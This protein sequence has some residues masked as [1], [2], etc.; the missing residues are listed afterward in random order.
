MPACP[1][2]AAEAQVRAW[3]D[4]V[5]VGL[6]ICPFAK[7]EIEAGRVRVCEPPAE[8]L[9]QALEAFADEALELIKS[10]TPATTLLVFARGFEGFND[11][12]NLL[13]MSQALLEECAWD[14][15]L[16]LASF[17]PDYCFEG[18]APDDVTNYTN[19][20]PLP[21]IHL[22]RQEDMARAI[23]SYPDVNAIPER[24]QRLARERGIG[25]FEAVLERC[26]RAQT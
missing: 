15:A 16:Q 25:Y 8:G 13:D 23:D 6:N 10:D 14:E 12:L 22:L 17:H 7:R 3:V 18:V 9:E 24:N 11:Y 26:R 5:V 1:H 20:S 2:A 19:R 4:T 21:I